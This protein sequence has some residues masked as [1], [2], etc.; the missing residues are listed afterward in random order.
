M[1][2]T[3]KTALIINLF[4]KSKYH[5]FQ[6]AETVKCDEQNSGYLVK[7]TN[8]EYCSKIIFII[9]DN[10]SYLYYG[11]HEIIKNNECLAQQLLNKIREY[12]K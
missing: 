6:S 4:R 5:I 1:I 12:C 2:K 9:S 10:K 7:M 8:N 11:Y 3:V